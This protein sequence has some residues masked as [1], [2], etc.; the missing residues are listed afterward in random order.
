M[1][2]Q[3]PLPRHL[4]RRRALARLAILFEQVWPNLW[5]P[6]GVAGVFLCAALLDLP[7]LLPPWFHIG[8][9]VVTG[10]LAAGLLVWG[11]RALT[12]PDLAAADRRLERESGLAHRPLAVLTDHPAT[13]ARAVEDSIADAVWR[14]HVTR[15]LGR[16]QHLR[17]GIPRP[18][19]A[20]RD[21]RGLRGALLVALVASLGIAGEDAP[22]RILAAL[23]P[24]MPRL[25]PSV[26]M[27]VRAWIT[28]PGYTRLPP[29]ILK[30]D[31]GPVSV[32]AGSHL[33]VSITGGSAGG[34][35]RA[36]DLAIGAQIAPFRPLDQNSFQADYDLT[37]NGTVTIQ[38]GGAALAS[39][40]VTILPDHPPTAAWTEQPGRARATQQLRLPW[41][42]S[43]DYGVAGLRAEI[44]LDAR[45]DA[46][47]VVI[48]LPLAG[49][50]PRKARGIGQH[51]LSAHPWAGLPVTARLFARDAIGQT[52]TGEAASFVLPERP[53][54][55]PIAKALIAARK[56]LSLTP[57]DRGEALEILD[58]LMLRPEAFGTDLGGWL[59]L[60]GIYFLLARDKS[61]EA[62]ELAQARLWQLA[63]HLEEGETE[64]T[65]RALEE[66]RQAAREAL[67][68]ATQEP[69]DANRQA[70]EQKLEALRQ[71]IDEH[72]RAMMEEA[73]RNREL[74][75]FDRDARQLTSRDL[76]RLA[77][78]AREAAREGRMDEA[79]KRM[80]ELERML[81]QLRNAHAQRGEDNP[82]QA[83]R[84][85]GRQQMSAA[86][87]MIARQGGLL[88]HAESRVDQ[89]MKFRGPPPTAGAD[90]EA[91]REA[92]RRVQQALRR[93]LG[94][95]M[96]QFGDLT[97]EVP[98]SLNEA[99]QAMREATQ[100]LGRGQDKA[101]GDAEREAIAA[102]QKGAREMGQA[103]ARQFGRGQEGQ[104]GEP[105]DEDG[106][107]TMGMMMGPG[108]R[109]GRSGRGTMPG[110]PPER[111]NPGGRDPLGRRFGQ[112]SSGA[113]ESADVTVP[114]ERERQRTQAI[115][116]EL[117]RRGGE[118]ERPRLEL[119]Y[120][121][122][123]LKQ[124]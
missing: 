55:H 112:G 8:L 120:I 56:S 19:L 52:G 63:L 5:P 66:A 54:Q 4:T 113:D 49:G 60:N 86:Q 124:F 23:Q 20:R 78:R 110:E 51:D 71:A 95:M 72:M 11:W 84:Q 111:A 9:L 50:A 64:R 85:R 77:E 98:P 99:D 67:D 32:P 104:D 91:E 94:E 119:D 81:D 117:R 36:P 80:A 34:G 79:T 22:N 115:Q 76:D 30:A 44:R 108:N 40:R 101:A 68:R 116:E 37:A 25:P 69:N 109:D 17:V 35:D 82:A 65:A 16:I 48:P 122:R 21:R 24:G 45:P 1:T 26:P 100:R 92:D 7:T 103:M 83:R 107:G 38:R 3:V 41:E 96:Q 90:P 58:G 47:P 46:P 33:T 93:A 13:Q 73:A 31:S 59:N 87:D 62:V 43:D 61:G 27:E 2:G 88:D 6:L 57:D 105:G 75:P 121:E 28:P 114:E 102:L 29:L 89:V 70:L 74:L 15:T 12:T 97:G 39:W 42:T 118:R 14:V 106:E 10:A 123:L 53:F 18:G